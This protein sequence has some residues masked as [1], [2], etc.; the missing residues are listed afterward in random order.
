MVLRNSLLRKCVPEY[1]SWSAAERAILCTTKKF[2]KSISAQITSQPIK[3]NGK[4]SAY[5]LLLFLCW[6]DA[7]S[8]R[9]V[10]RRTFRHVRQKSPKNWRCRRCTSHAWHS[11]LIIQRTETVL[12]NT[13]P[14]NF[15]VRFFGEIHHPGACFWLLASAWQFEM[16]QKRSCLTR[17]WHIKVVIEPN[18]TIGQLVKTRMLTGCGTTNISNTK[19]HTLNW[20]LANLM[21]TRT[22]GIENKQF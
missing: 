8:W 18:A 7:S 2:V 21:P 17:K 15:G 22:H 10:R 4:S 19:R 20:L 16:I 11:A 5:F 14:G 13:L 1:I 12:Y 9:V 3:I 6:C